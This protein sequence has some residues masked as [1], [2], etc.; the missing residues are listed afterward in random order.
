MGTVED[1]TAIKAVNRKEGHG[2][3]ARNRNTKKEHETGRVISVV[4]KMKAINLVHLL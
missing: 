1:I 2:S 3:L 4:V